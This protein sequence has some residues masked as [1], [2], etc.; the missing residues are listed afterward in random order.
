MAPAQP[1][2]VEGD[3]EPTDHAWLLAHKWMSSAKLQE[4]VKAEGLVYKKGK[5]SAIEEN[6]LKNAIQQYREVMCRFTSLLL[7]VY[8]QPAEQWPL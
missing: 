5:F 3:P 6:A 2:R 1:Q 8:Q 7:P 4:M